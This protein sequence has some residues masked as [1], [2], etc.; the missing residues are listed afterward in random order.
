[1]RV[2]TDDDSDGGSKGGNLREGEIHEND[3][4]FD[5]VHAEIGVNA[6]ENQTGDER[7][8]EKRKNLHLSLQVIWLSRAPALAC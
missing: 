8:N 4:A 3:A 7:G 5:D 1:M 2:H 6:S